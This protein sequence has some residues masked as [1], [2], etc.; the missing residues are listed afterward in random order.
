MIII[1]KF[2]DYYD[3][4]VG[5]YGRDEKIIYNRGNVNKQQFET[6]KFY[7][8]KPKFLYRLFDTTYTFN[9][10]DVAESYNC[11]IL[12]IC[13]K[14]YFLKRKVKHSNHFNSNWCEYSIV[15]DKDLED[16]H[17]YTKIID[18][19]YPSYY[20]FRKYKKEVVSKLYGVYDKNLL[21]ISYEIKNPVFLITMKNHQNII[22]SEKT[23]I[24]KDIV[25]IPGLLKP[26][27][28]YQQISYFIGNV[29]NE[30]KEEVK[31][32]DNSKIIKAGFDLKTSFRNV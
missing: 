23:P 10:E 13:G 12:V 11:Y 14:L 18:C 30:P 29:L 3:F 17:L 22:I 27:D 4:L 28:I 7:N 21:N 26:E 2:K 32:S 16:T 5:E 24:L 20:Q 19:L 25:G 15:T 8:I 31:I 1:S 9:N 6:S